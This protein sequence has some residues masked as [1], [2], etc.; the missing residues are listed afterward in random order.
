MQSLCRFKI[1][2]ELDSCRRQR[3]PASA[4]AFIG[5]FAKHELDQ[6]TSGSLGFSTIQCWRF[7]DLVPALRVDD[8]VPGSASGWA[9]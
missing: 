2:R 1:A 6:V 4:D 7:D 5:L 8:P 9:F 3:G